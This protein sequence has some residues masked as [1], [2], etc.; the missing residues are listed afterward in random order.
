MKNKNNT[1]NLLTVVFSIIGICMLIAGICIGIFG[2]V[3]NQKWDSVDACIQDIVSYGHGEERDYDVFVTYEYN[4]Q[5]YDRVKTNFYS[6]SMYVGQW[7]E[8]KVDPEHP[9]KMTS[10]SVNVF[11]SL[12]FVLMGLIFGSVG[13]VPW[14][15]RGRRK[16][17]IKKLIDEGKCVVGKVEQ[18]GF[19]RHYSVNDVHPYIVYATYTDEYTGEV[20]QYKSDSIWYNV[21]EYVNEG[22]DVKIY[23]DREDDT[24]YFVDV[25]GIF[26]TMG[27]QM[28]Y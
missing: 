5:I 3:K 16:K 25:E 13:L 20:K 23:I 11:L 1:E 7:I 10:A 15:L 27:S 8:V 4:G 9:E 2:A 26:A 17:L 28:A 18:I 14:I 6:S 21:P 12:F 22:D 19:N 24:K